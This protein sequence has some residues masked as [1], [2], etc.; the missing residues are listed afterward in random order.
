[1][2]SKVAKVK[3][4]MLQFY[5]QNGGVNGMTT[6]HTHRRLSKKPDRLKLTATSI[7]TQ[8]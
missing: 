2:N 1:M 6:S 5:A 7:Q 4:K 3:N 8:L